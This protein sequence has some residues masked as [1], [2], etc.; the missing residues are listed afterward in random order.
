MLRPGRSGTA[1]P[2]Q[3]REHGRLQQQGDKPKGKICFSVI[4]TMLISQW[5]SEGREVVTVGS[6]T[7]AA[8]C[9]DRRAGAELLGTV[10]AM[11]LT[12]VR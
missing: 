7:F 8:R 2:R 3:P 6:L 5:E 9:P 4:F 10:A 11:T 1:P 12:N